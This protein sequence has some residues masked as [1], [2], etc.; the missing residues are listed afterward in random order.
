MEF[1][2]FGAQQMTVCLLKGVF[3]ILGAVLGIIGPTLRGYSQNES[4]N[5]LFICIY[6]FVLMLFTIFQRYSFNA[7]A[8]DE[9]AIDDRKTVLISQNSTV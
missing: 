9:S 2:K 1:E 4:E 7:I 5:L 6:S 3:N 8:F